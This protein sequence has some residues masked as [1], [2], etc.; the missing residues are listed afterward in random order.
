MKILGKM[1]GVKGSWIHENIQGYNT[2]LILLILIRYPEHILRLTSPEINISPEN[3]LLPDELY[4]FSRWNGPFWGDMLIFMVVYN[5]FQEH[6]NLTAELFEV[7]SCHCAR[8]QSK[9][10]HLELTV[11][12]IGPNPKNWTKY[13]HLRTWEKMEAFHTFFPS[14]AKFFGWRT[15]WPTD[16]A[17]RWIL[18]LLDL[19][20]VCWDL[21]LERWSQDF[22]T[23]H[24]RYAMSERIAIFFGCLQMAITP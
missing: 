7:A 17:L 18:V 20:M 12:K 15:F 4:E 14:N 11:P 23:M 19:K 13:Y 16:D 6:Q 1:G 24:S 3:H 21:R 9:R 2:L 8:T 10:P 5:K 22:S